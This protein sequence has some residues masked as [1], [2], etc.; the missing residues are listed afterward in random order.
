[1]MEK[2]LSKVILSRLAWTIFI[3]KL[4]LLDIIYTYKVRKE[5]SDSKLITRA[6]FYILFLLVFEE[7]HDCWMTIASFSKV[8]V[9]FYIIEWFADVL[10]RHQIKE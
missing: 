2:H 5:F 9:C 7:L 1:M 3:Q 4:S 6:F 8:L 10:Y